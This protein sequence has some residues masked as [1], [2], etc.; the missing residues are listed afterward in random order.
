MNW[1]SIATTAEVIAALGVIASLIYVARQ[2]RASQVTAADTNRLSRAHG[3]RE[4]LMANA[5]NDALRKSVAK[6]YEFEAYYEQM[7]AALDLSVDDA[8]RADFHNAYYFWLHWGQYSSTTDP[9][10]LDELK[11]VFRAYLIPAFRY[12]WENSPYAKPVLEPGFIEFVD[13]ILAEYGDEA[14]R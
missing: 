7:A 9:N 1:E 8:A 12:S 11:K 4:M 13:K 2:L 5:T 10:D 6:A 14:F 3:V